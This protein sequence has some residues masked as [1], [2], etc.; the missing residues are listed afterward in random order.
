M[1]KLE[2]FKLLSWIKRGRQRKLTILALKEEEPIYAVEL[3]KRINNNV[4]E[5]TKLSLREISRQLNNFKN[6]NLVLCLDEEMPY[7]R[8]YVLTKKGEKIKKEFDNYFKT[9]Q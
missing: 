7:S 9:S 8:S 6:Q 1:N 5:G 3:K 4:K 2:I